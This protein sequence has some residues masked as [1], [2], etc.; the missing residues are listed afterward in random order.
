[1]PRPIVVAPDSFKGTFAAPIVAEAIASGI[2]Q[3]GVPAL[4]LP[5]ADG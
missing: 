4:R 2:E 1:M 3:Q 5:I